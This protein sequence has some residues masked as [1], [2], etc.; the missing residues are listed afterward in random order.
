MRSFSF[1]CAR[2]EVPI[3]LHTPP[4][5]TGCFP[6]E[7][8]PSQPCC[9]KKE[10]FLPLTR[11]PTL[12]FFAC[13]PSFTPEYI[14]ALP[15]AARIRSDSGGS[16]ARNPGIQAHSSALEVPG[17]QLLCTAAT[18]FSAAL[19]PNVSWIGCLS[20][21]NILLCPIIPRLSL[22]TMLVH[23]DGNAP[24]LRSKQT[25][26]VGFPSSPWRSP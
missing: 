21:N 1:C 5:F 12:P 4:S 2:V 23:C 17:E 14:Q 20:P 25:G 18:A 26:M 9:T 19:S 10:A 7:C 6:A 22:L 3:T 11:P 16:Y 13:M 15:A 24:S 8:H